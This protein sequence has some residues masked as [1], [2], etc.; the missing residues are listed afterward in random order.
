MDSKSNSQ[1][2]PP[3]FS[4]IIAGNIDGRTDNIRY[5][6]RQFHRLQASILTHL[7]E[8][9]EAISQDSG[10]SV[11]EVQTE[12]CLA[13]KEI[14]SHYSGLSLEKSVQLEY[15]VAR[16][17]DHLNRKKGAGIV[18]IIPTTH[19][20]FYSVIAALSAALAAGNCIVLE[21]PKTTSRVTALL[22]SVLPRALDSDTF[23]I[24]DSRPDAAFL[25]TTLVLDQQSSECPTGYATLELPNTLRTV[26]V[27]DRTANLQEAA[28]D[29]VQARFAFDGRSPYAPDVVLVNQFCMQPFVELVI[30]HAAKHLGSDNHGANSLP[31]R[32]RQASLLDKLGSEGVKVIVSGTGWGVALL[33][34]RDSPLL[35]AKLSER[36]LLLH[37]V[38]SLDDAI[39]LCN[40]S[41]THAATYTF[42]APAAAK[43]VSESIDAHTAW[44]NHVP[45]DILVGPVVPLS[46]GGN[47]HTRYTTED[48]QV[49]RPQVVNQTTTTAI[50]KA[51]LAGK[52]VQS[53]RTLQEIL[54]PLP[55][56]QQRPGHKIGYF[57]QG[58]ITGGLITLT[59]LITIVS[60][61]GYWVLRM[62]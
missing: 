52:S 57:E 1:S 43:Y 39:N 13:L 9:K 34:N 10:H 60:A 19:T 20:T 32:P 59:S 26:A 14:R 50:A 62:R 44:I 36:L 29:V 30:K 25:R 33:Q 12:V 38:S 45:Y 58:I 28:V 22:R 48:F 2:H 23:A 53:D 55:E 7:A 56:I 21:L 37:P 4:A 40:A 18:Y 61:A 15:R 41:G 24:S 49:P 42:A 54:S 5:R 47:L 35:R 31:K 3:Q 46:Y 11:E 27:V 8:L 6:Q 17:E 51:L 16:G